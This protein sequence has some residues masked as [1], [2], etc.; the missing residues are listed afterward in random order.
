MEEGG[1]RGERW[2]VYGKVAKGNLAQSLI[3][4]VGEREVATS[5]LY[6]FSLAITVGM[7]DRSDLL[8][9]LLAW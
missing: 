9:S 5:S 2:K 3:R 8:G 4:R 6:T 7:S 1:G